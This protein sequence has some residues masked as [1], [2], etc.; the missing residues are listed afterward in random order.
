MSGGLE[1]DV[2]FYFGAIFSRLFF[3]GFLILIHVF[4]CVNNVWIKETHNIPMVWVW[5]QTCDWFE[6][7]E[8]YINVYNIL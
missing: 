3:R 4:L 2:A 5:D 7:R 1:D 8:A 6:G